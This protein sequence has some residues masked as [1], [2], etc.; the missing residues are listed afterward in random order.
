MHI[1]NM[2]NNIMEPYQVYLPIHN[3][4][5]KMKDQYRI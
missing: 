5:N 1:N 4:K 3:E 2:D